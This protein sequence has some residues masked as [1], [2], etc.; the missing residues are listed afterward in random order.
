[1]VRVFKILIDPRED[2]RLL[3][4]GLALAPHVIED[5]SRQGSDRIKRA[6]IA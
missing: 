6:S 5:A 2:L 3:V 1:M 4:S